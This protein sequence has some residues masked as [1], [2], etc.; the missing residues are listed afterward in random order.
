MRGLLS[1][2]VLGALL[3][4]SGPPAT[5]E[6]A[7]TSHPD[8]PGQ[9]ADAFVDAVALWLDGIEAEALPALAALAQAGNPAAQIL[10]ALID[11][12][13]SLQGPW[14]ARLPRAER[15]ALLRAPGGISG[16]SLMHAA[17]ET[18]PIAGHWLTLWSVTASPQLILDFAAAGEARAAREAVVAL[19]ARERRGLAEVAAEPGFPA[20]LRFLVWQEWDEARADEVAAERAALAPGDPQRGIDGTAAGPDDAAL[21]GWLLTAS[22]AGPIGAF[23]ADRCAETADDCALA[24]W[25]ALGSYRALLLLGSPSERLIPAATFH[26]SARGHTALLRRVL[27]AVDARGRRRQLAQAEERDSCFAGQLETEAQRYMPRHD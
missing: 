14:L 13:P 23:C 2:I 3:L 26:E 19:A 18:A 5:A 9:R 27:L 22:E 25:E 24:A 4:A 7:S 16:R 21:A 6:D 15:I 17:A 10:V 1:G 11:K 20:A 12:T 8:I